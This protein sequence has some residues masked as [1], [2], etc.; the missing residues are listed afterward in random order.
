M[1]N[2]RK[3]RAQGTPP[4][5]RKERSRAV[6]GSKRFAGPKQRQLSANCYNRSASISL[7]SSRAG[8]RIILKATRRR[9]HQESSIG[10]RSNRTS[11]TWWKGKRSE[12]GGSKGTL[13]IKFL[14]LLVDVRY[15]P[16][17]RVLVGFQDQKITNKMIMIKYKTLL[18]KNS[19]ITS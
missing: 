5:K 8:E 3:S 13:N 11:S 10:S 17:I 7:V 14:G 2:R 6:R 16:L 9:N 1:I 4:V 18:M 19:I 12:K 15:G